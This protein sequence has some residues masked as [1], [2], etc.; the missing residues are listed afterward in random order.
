MINEI[1]ENVKKL[2][3]QEEEMWEPDEFHQMWIFI[4][5][6]RRAAN[7]VYQKAGKVPDE[8][9]EKMV[10]S[11]YE[12]LVSRIIKYTPDDELLQRLVNDISKRLG[13]K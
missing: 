11:I 13:G 6:I 8:E 1:Y 7:Y 12:E 3:E 2:N 10:D 9:R 4:Q 5:D